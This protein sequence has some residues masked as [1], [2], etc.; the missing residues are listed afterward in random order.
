MTFEEWKE[1]NQMEP[2]GVIAYWAEAAWNAA[3][4]N[5]V[6]KSTH[7]N[8]DELRSYMTSQ[9]RAPAEKSDV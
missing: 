8:K 4:R 2:T 7:N 9:R 5:A 3:L 1:A 6:A